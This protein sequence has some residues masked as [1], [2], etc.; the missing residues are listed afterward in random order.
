MAVRA[1]EASA[2]W[3][4]AG[5]AGAHAWPDDLARLMLAALR[6]FVMLFALF[7]Y[8]LELERLGR[9]MEEHRAKATG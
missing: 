2:G 4:A 9:A 1:A 3:Q 8:A 7:C 5:V 6:G